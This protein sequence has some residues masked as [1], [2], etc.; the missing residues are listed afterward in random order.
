MIGKILFA[1]REG[2]HV[3]K[4]IGDVRVTLGPTINTFLNRLGA[5]SNFKSI[6]IDLSETDGI[7]STSLGLLA[8]IALKTGEAFDAV[9]TI[10]S[11]NDDIT[12]ILISM[13]FDK[14]FV[15]L[16]ELVTDCGQLG[17]LPKEIISEANLRDQVL[18]AH[19]VLMS[20][21]ESNEEEFKDLVQALENEH[22]SSSSISG[23]SIR[24]DRVA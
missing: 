16:D 18:E 9:P 17:E 11:P 14:V 4:F 24:K 15:I 1:E 7:D 23:E 12:R 13:G 5:C 10:I 21:N 22:D 20:L 2:I 6:V 8:K 3:L 19:K